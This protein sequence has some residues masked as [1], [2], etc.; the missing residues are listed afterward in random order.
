MESS[1]VSN[2]LLN[3]IKRNG[4]SIEQYKKKWGLDCKYEI[5]YNITED[6]MFCHE[7]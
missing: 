1:I 3:N 5:E 6:V 7:P 2:N 4:D